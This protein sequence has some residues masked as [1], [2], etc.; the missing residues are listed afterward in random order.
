LSG[1]LVRGVGE[2]I[3]ERLGSFLRAQHSP[4]GRAGVG[5]GQ[6]FGPHQVAIRVIDSL[7]WVARLP[8]PSASASSN[9]E[10]LGNLQDTHTFRTS[11]FRTLR[12]VALSIFVRSRASALAR[13]SIAVNTTVPERIANAAAFIDRSER[14]NQ[15]LAIAKALCASKTETEA[16]F[17]LRKRPNADRVLQAFEQVNVTLALLRLCLSEFYR[18]ENIRRFMRRWLSIDL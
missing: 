18:Q 9:P 3:P 17:F 13:R 6:V 4:R 10:R 15:F 11:C 1:I 2:R 14:A 5:T 7:Y 8:K 12:S 16:R